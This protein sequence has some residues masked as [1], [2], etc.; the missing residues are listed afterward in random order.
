[1][2]RCAVEALISPC[3]LIR[4]STQN[5]TWVWVRGLSFLFS[6]FDA[7]NN[8]VRQDNSSWQSINHPYNKRPETLHETYMHDFGRKMSGF[9]LSSVLVSVIYCVDIGVDLS[10]AMQLAI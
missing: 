2:M 5:Q 10:H 3:Y 1:M 4:L 7:G 8:Q 6:L 9:R